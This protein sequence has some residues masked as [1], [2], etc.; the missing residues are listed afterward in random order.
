VVYGIILFAA[1]CTSLYMGRMLWTVF[2][3][4]A[5]SE[6]ARHAREGGAFIALPLMV[7]GA[8]S[9]GAGWF[10]F[11]WDWAG[12]KM[13]AMLPTVA[14]LAL[15]PEFKEV[16]AGVKAL[17][18]HVEPLLLAAGALCCVGGFIFTLFFYG[19]GSSQDRLAQRSP[20]LYTVLEKHG[21]FE[22]IYDWYVTKVQQRFA[23]LVGFFDLIFISGL[24]VRGTAGVV[25]LCGLIARSLHVGSIHGYVYW[26]LAGLILFSA[27]ALGWIG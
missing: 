8:L 10:V 7:L 20:L 15:L 14:T 18:D 11:G 26:F 22:D 13:D 3:G 19:R 5:N 23:D 17:G 4:Q 1:L 2:F 12:G 25:G 27:F 6:H 21:W 9:L 16:H 24:L